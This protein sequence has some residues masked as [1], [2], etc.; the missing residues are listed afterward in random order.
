M[1][2][3]QDP[4]AVPPDRMRRVKDAVAMVVIMMIAMIV[5]IVMSH[6]Y[7]QGL[8]RRGKRTEKE[9]PAEEKGE[10]IFHTVWLTGQ[11]KTYSN[12]NEKLSL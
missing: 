8:G 7:C 9:R 5:A 6:D 4:V 11:L 3:N 12:K 1:G 10:G 2:R